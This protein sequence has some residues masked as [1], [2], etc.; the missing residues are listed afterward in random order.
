MSQLHQFRA[1]IG[2]VRSEARRAADSLTEFKRKFAEAV[3]RVS[4]TIGDTANREDRDMIETFQQAEKGVDEAIAALR[5]AAK[6]ASTYAG[7]P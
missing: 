3:S 2:P 5:K 7:R 6:A 4:T 1:Q